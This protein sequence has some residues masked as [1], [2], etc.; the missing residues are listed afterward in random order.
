[1]SYTVHYGK[2]DGYCC[3][4]RYKV[5]D[6]DCMKGKIQAS[7]LENIVTEELRL[8]TEH[9]LKYKQELL[10]IGFRKDICES[11]LDRKRKLE[12]EEQKLQVSKMQLYEKHK[13]GVTDKE[14]YLF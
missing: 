9:F 13:K 7:I 5:K 3:P 8:Y 6:C 4:Y 12:A 2:T 11:L 1:M 10:S 14:T